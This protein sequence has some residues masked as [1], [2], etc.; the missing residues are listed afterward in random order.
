MA[1]VTNIIETADK[2]SN[3]LREKLGGDAASCVLAIALGKLCA[4]AGLSLA[5]VLAMAEVTH[6]EIHAELSRGSVAA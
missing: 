6:R 3:E 2:T 4:E 1:Q 5:D